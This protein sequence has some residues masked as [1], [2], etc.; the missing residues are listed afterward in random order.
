M[1]N[2]KNIVFGTI[3]VLVMLI[4]SCGQAG[5]DVNLNIDD[6]PPISL[7]MLTSSLKVEAEIPVDSVN[8]GVDLEKIIYNYQ[9]ASTGSNTIKIGIKLSLYGKATDGIKLRF[10]GTTALPLV[11]TEPEPAWLSSDYKNKITKV[12]G[13]TWGWVYLIPPT[14]LSSASPINGS[15][16]I[17]GDVIN[18]ILKQDNLWIVVD[19]TTTDPIATNNSFTIKNQ[20]IK[21]V[22]SK[23]TGYYPGVF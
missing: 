20:S 1:K 12:G 6:T 16:K 9:I 15:S 21:A 13:D 7:D 5:F 23:A 3:A 4:T 8:L 10:I 2:R 11:V 18:E 14:N 19:I 17:T 22:G